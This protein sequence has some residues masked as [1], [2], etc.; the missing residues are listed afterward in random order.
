MGIRQR[1]REESGMTAE[2][3]TKEAGSDRS[4]SN[5]DFKFNPIKCSDS[6]KALPVGNGRDCDGHSDLKQGRRI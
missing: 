6:G 1:K 4:C 5:C 2:T 3:K